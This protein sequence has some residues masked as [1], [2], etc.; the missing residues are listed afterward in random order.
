LDG[1]VANLEHAVDKEAQAHLRRD[2]PGADM[3]AVEQAEMLEILH[4]VADRGG[5]EAEIHHPGQRA[6]ADRLAGLEIRLDQPREDRTAAPVEVT[7]CWCGVRH[8]FF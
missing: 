2:A 7:E 6:R 8:S 4:D 3:R 5:R 1:Y